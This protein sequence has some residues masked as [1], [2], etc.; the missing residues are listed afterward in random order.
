MGPCKSLL[1][2]LY[3]RRKP[4]DFTPLTFKIQ[5]AWS[6]CFK[7]SKSRWLFNKVLR[8]LRFIPVHLL[9]SQ[10]LLKSDDVPEFFTCSFSSK[11]TREIP[12]RLIPI[13][14]YSGIDWVYVI[15]K[16]ANGFWGNW[17]F[18]YTN[19]AVLG[20]AIFHASVYIWICFPGN[21]VLPTGK[22]PLYRIFKTIKTHNSGEA[23]FFEK[24]GTQGKQIQVYV[25]GCHTWWVNEG[26]WPKCFSCSTMRHGQAHWS[27]MPLACRPV[28]VGCSNGT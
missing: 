1:N 14:C 23:L 20:L 2:M 25:G 11:K 22:S 4:I 5:N 8:F 13:H 18:T 19:R 6:S 9:N 15:S 7:E 3:S 28:L 12:N 27:K 16:I 21:C 10:P 17:Y 24:H 26:Q